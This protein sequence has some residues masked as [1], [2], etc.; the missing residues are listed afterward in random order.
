MP[1]SHAVVGTCAFWA[2]SRRL[3][4]SDS[5]T[6]RGLLLYWSLPC[7]THFPHLLPSP[8]QSIVLASTFAVSHNI[9]ESKPLDDNMTREV[10][11]NQVG[12]GGRLKPVL[13][14]DCNPCPFPC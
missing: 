3:E 7:D 8:T 14:K 5:C 6:W 12:E 10:M 9:P 13:T 4:A 11:Y 2:A 1:T